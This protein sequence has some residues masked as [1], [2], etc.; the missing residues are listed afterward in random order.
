MTK[1]QEQT[2]QIIEFSP[3]HKHAKGPDK[4]TGAV[5]SGFSQDAKTTLISNENCDEK[6]IPEKI[7][8]GAWGATD[9]HAD[10][11]GFKAHLEQLSKMGARQLYKAEA[12]CHR[13]MLQRS[14]EKG[15]PV[16]DDF[17]TFTGFLAEVGPMPFPGCTLDRVNNNDPKYALGKVRWATATVQNNNKSDNIIIYG[18]HGEAFTVAEIA[19]AQGKLPATIRQRRYDGWTDA[20][21]LAG[22]RKTTDH[23]G[24]ATSL[25]MYAEFGLNDKYEKRLK[26]EREEE[27]RKRQRQAL[28]NRLQDLSRKFKAEPDQETF[29]KL[30]TLIAEKVESSKAFDLFEKAWSFYK[31]IMPED[32]F[33]SLPEFVR[34]WVSQI[35]PDYQ[36]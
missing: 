23:K 21:I 16:H 14:K 7:T 5:T 24:S 9:Y 22:K 28:N 27:A 13:N 32:S 25:A 3:G 12:T 31:P 15:V 19:T 18:S 8:T 17:K 2:A 29:V 30:A 34:S 26:E 4:T 35:D 1:A 10:T 33:D 6:I 11:E 36:Y 20:E